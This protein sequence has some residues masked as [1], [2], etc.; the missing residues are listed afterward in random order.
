RRRERPPRAK[1]TSYAGTTRTPCLASAAMTAACVPLPRSRA[2]SGHRERDR[3]SHAAHATDERWGYNC[4]DP[5]LAERRLEELTVIEAGA[6]P[7]IPRSS[8]F[9]SK[10]RSISAEG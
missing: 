5:I 7:A 10:A 1:A 8:S 6:C 9:A 4:R 3:R 2:S